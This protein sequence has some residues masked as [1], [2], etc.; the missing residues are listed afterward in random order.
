MADH[1]SEMEDQ[2]EKANPVIVPEQ[3]GQVKII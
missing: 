3:N 1:L 2:S